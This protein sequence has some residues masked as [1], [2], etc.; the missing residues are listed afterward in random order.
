MIRNARKEDAKAIAPLILVI[1]E[2]MELPFVAR[3]GVDQ[4]L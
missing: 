1:L 4:T 2:D 3:Y